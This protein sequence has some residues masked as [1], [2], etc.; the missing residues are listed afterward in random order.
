MELCSLPSHKCLEFLWPYTCREFF[1][2]DL[3]SIK[4]TSAFNIISKLLI[5]P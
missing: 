5:S 4:K 3:T 1:K 2:I